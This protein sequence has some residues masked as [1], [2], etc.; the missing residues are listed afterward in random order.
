MF[1][2]TGGLGGNIARRIHMR[3]GAVRQAVIRYHDLQS[4]ALRH[5]THLFKK[6]TWWFFLAEMQLTLVFVALLGIASSEP[7]IQ[8]PLAIVASIVQLLMPLM[9]WPF[10][11]MYENLAI[12]VAGCVHLALELTAMAQLVASMQSAIRPDDTSVTAQLKNLETT[13]GVLFCLGWFVLFGLLAYGIGGNFISIQKVKSRLRQNFCCC[14]R[15]RVRPGIA[16]Q[17]DK[18]SPPEEEND[19][20]SMFAELLPA[21]V[22]PGFAMLNRL[23]KEKLVRYHKLYKELNIL[24]TEVVATC[25]QAMIR[26]MKARKSFRRKKEVIDTTL[27]LHGDHSLNDLLAEVDGSMT[28]QEV[29]AKRKWQ[30]NETAKIKHLLSMRQDTQLSEIDRAIIEFAAENEDMIS[31]VVADTV[32]GNVAKQKKSQETPFARQKRLLKK[33]D[34]KKRGS[35]L[36]NRQPKATPTAPRRVTGGPRSRR[37]LHTIAATKISINRV[38]RN[39]NSI[40]QRRLDREHM[41]D[42]SQANL[43]MK[44][45]DRETGDT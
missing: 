6:S 16:A 10:E 45:Y 39:R 42:K 20:Q 4:K 41:S 2:R 5:M 9:A 38:K 26:G 43:I 17:A 33:T 19:A 36:A 32:E 31:Q 8:I 27:Q 13:L 11:E 23:P 18:K 29:K 21:I 34:H 44:E 28:H 25:M 14:H 30:E 35:L 7:Q 22:R 3:T 40:Q 12:I 1:D 24:H 37:N 15:V